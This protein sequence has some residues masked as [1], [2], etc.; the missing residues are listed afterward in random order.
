MY[1][2]PFSHPGGND[3]KRANTIC[4]FIQD[5]LTK[6]AVQGNKLEKKLSLLL[7]GYQSRS[8]LLSQKITQ[9]SDAIAETKRDLE[10]FRTLRI[11]EADAVPRRLEAIRGEVAFL[12]RREREAQ[13]IYR[14]RREEL[15]DL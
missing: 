15:E 2:P 7:G 13:E 8:K 12:D 1:A 14:A 3:N 9:A 5:K 4:K 6:D 10:S 11:S